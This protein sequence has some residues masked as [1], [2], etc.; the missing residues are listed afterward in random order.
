VGA[1]DRLDFSVFEGLEER[2]SSID[3]KKHVFYSQPSYNL[4]ASLPLKEKKYI[5]IV[6]TTGI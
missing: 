4:V 6:M 5:K 2:V 3:C 1:R